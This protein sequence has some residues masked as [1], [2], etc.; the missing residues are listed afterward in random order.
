MNVDIYD[1]TNPIITFK[2]ATE[3]LVE[4]F[5]GVTLVTTTTED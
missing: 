5:Q 2:D 3:V 4:H 1:E